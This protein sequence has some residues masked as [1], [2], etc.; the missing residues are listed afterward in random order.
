VDLTQKQKDEIA[1]TQLFFSPEILHNSSK[2][3]FESDMW[4]F[5]IIIY[6]LSYLSMPFEG[7]STGE[8][9]KNVLSK[10]PKQPIE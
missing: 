1:G 9:Y 7:N 3:S 5:G 2:N 8:Y 4:A 6:Y 10:P